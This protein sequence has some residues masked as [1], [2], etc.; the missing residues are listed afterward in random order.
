M[1]SHPELPFLAAG[2]I[3]IIGGTIRERKIPSNTVR[4]LVGTGVLTLVAATTSETKL[5][6]LVH[7]IGMLLV[8]GVT[9]AAVNDYNHR[10]KK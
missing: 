5:A 2:A 1:V 10:I 3:A 4:A 9:I 8:L 6:P 7:A